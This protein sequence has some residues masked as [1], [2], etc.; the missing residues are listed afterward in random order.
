MYDGTVQAFAPFM[1][2]RSV[3]G[4]D[5]PEQTRWVHRMGEKDAGIP[6]ERSLQSMD[7][8]KEKEAA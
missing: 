5:E 3:K 7:E 4:G 6:V 8:A 2:L 1:Y